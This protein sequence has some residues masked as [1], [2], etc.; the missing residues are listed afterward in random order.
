MLCPH[1][2]DEI[3]YTYSRHILV[4]TGLS[5]LE[6]DQAGTPHFK[7]YETKY[8]FK[9]GP[10]S[11]ERCVSDPKFGVVLKISTKGK[12]LEVRITPSGLIRVGQVK[13]TKKIK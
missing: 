4:C 10:A 11:V 12:T 1:C 7:N 5:S 13:Q 6:F 2:N 9:W 8:G 3:G